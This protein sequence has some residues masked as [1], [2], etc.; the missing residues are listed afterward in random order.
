MYK[1]LPIFRS[2]LNALM[3]DCLIIVDSFEKALSVASMFKYSVFLIEHSHQRMIFIEELNTVVVSSYGFLTRVKKISYNKKDIIIDRVFLD[4]KPPSEEVFRNISKL[5]Q[6]S[7][8]VVFV[9]DSLQSGNAIISF[10]SKFPKRKFYYVEPLFLSSVVSAVKKAKSVD[11]K[12]I[13][14]LE[15]NDLIFFNAVD[16]KTFSPLVSSMNFGDN[17]LLSL[18]IGNNLVEFPKNKAAY[19]FDLDKLLSKSYKRAVVPVNVSVSL[20]QED[21]VEIS[22]KPPYTTPELL[23]E[24]SSRFSISV[25]EILASLLK[26]YASGLINNPFKSISVNT[27]KRSLRKFLKNSFQDRSFSKDFFLVPN[28]K[29]WALSNLNTLG[30]GFSD[31]DA[32]VFGLIRARFFYAFSHSCSGVMDLFEMSVS[33]FFSEQDVS[34]EKTLLVDVSC[35]NHKL[36]NVFSLEEGVYE[37]KLLFESFPNSIRKDELLDFFFYSLNYYSRFFIWF[38]LRRSLADRSIFFL[39]NHPMKK[40]PALKYFGRSVSDGEFQDFIKNFI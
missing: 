35:L 20:V 14:N 27:F 6:R 37:G 34:F 2:S 13:Q 10:Y 16:K 24:V 23:F 32:L 12:L 33:S 5:M 22:Q 40:E 25:K 11:S 36:F 19:F 30:R 3:F 26:L 18:S 21:V 4:S 1:P 9:L 31:T 8:K 29:F 17:F 28:Q 15:M 7:K 39:E 38:V